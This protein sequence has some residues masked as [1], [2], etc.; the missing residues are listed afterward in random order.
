MPRVLAIS[1]QVA[2]GSI[3][4]SAAVPALQALGHEVIALP[5]ILLS[6]HPGHVRLAGERLSPDLLGRMIETLDAN[7]W[8]AGID[9]ILT[10]YLP[11]ADHVA[12]A[13]T[14]IERVK[15]RS[16]SALYLCDPILGDHPKGLYIAPD[17]AEAIRDRLVPRAD[18]L[19]M[20][21]FEAEW[22]CGMPIGSADEAA[23]M[24]RQKRWPAAIITSLPTA[25]DT[26]LTN[27]LV[28]GTAPSVSI[29]VAR[30]ECVPNGT[31]DLLGA[32]WLGHRFLSG[33]NAEAL[34]RAVLGVEL[35]LSRS[36]GADE[37]QLAASLRELAP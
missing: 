5:T 30:R 8:L 22:L 21:R 19:K 31:G 36:A 3:G 16:P 14:A 27:L 24:V 11:S 17:A 29:D 37:L 10:G 18:V 32:L 28:E 2:R 25:D 1:S 26:K 12:V 33:D 23:S 9:A 6:N 20:N 15:Q 13:V 7:G 4:L 35:V 34:R